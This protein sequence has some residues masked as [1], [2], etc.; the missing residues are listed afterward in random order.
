MSLA[1]EISADRQRQA[2]D[3]YVHHP[4]V[5]LQAI[6]TFLGVS[7]RTFARLR[8]RWGWPPRR[9]VALSKGESLERKAIV[10]E[11]EAPAE[12]IGASASLREAA[13][14]LTR[15]ARS[16][17]DA[18]VKAQRAG[19][20]VD[21]DKTARALASYAKTLTTAQALLEQEG[22]RLDENEH[23]DETP[24]SIHELRDELARHLDRVIAEEESRGGDSLLV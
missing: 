16:H 12:K 21:H 20:A 10:V 7:L 3:Y 6:A 9:V 22:S 15:V 8:Q 4:S 11:G 5:S 24:R 19:G 17:I 1:I 23:Q 2:Y 14:S 13:W 18:L